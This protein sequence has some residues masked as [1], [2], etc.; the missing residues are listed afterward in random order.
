MS[1]LKFVDLGLPLATP[2]GE[3][4]DAMGSSMAPQIT[5]HDHKE[6]AVVM[7]RIFGV[8]PED[9]PDG[10]GWAAEEVTLITHAGTHF[11]GSY[12]FAPTSEGREAKTVD[13][14]P[15][16][17]CYSDAFVLDMRHKKP[18]ELITAADVQDS[19]KKIGY[20]IKPLD[21]ALIMT[22]T[23]K[24]WGT[25]EYWTQHPGVGRESTLW[26][27]EQGVKVMGIDSPG[28]DRPFGVM[29]EEYKRTGN[30]AVIWEAH[31]A[32]I[33]K[34][35]FHIEKMANLDELSPHGFKVACFPISIE[36]ASAG[37]VRPVA[38]LEE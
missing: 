11:D 36:R 38:I 14:V 20:T 28:F 37:W 17:Y 8:R 26:L 32:G 7:S 16:E 1:K 29:A 5:Y 19:L 10:L 23:D 30:K 31:F 27:A 21:I 2:S 18:A 25:E 12:H 22:G 4:K 15:L 24:L 9:L 34:E 6:G 35:Y 13:Q 3:Q 33:I